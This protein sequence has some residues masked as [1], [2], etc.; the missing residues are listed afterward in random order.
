MED[1]QPDEIIN[2]GQTPEHWK[3]RRSE[4]GR[5]AERE[6]VRRES[7]RTGMLNG[8]EVDAEL[9]EALR[10]LNAAGVKTEYSC[11][12]VSP[13]DE[14]EEHSLYA[15]ITL[16]ESEAA[17][18]FVDYA[19]RRMGRRL[20]VSYE[21]AGRRYDLSSFMLGQNRSFCLLL[22]SCAREFAQQG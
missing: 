8:V 18:N 13:L 7:K 10:L 22:E 14:P 20:L 2:S 12:G 16:I 17:R 9:L 15:Y 3:R 1:I 19:M 6:K 5:W 11:A 21:P 4:L